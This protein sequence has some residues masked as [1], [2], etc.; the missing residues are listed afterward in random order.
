MVS[1]LCKV[2]KWE[3]KK[4]TYGQLLKD[5]RAC[6]TE[7]SKMGMLREKYNELWLF[8]LVNLGDLETIEQYKDYLQQ[9]L[10][11]YDDFLNGK[12]NYDTMY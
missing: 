2:V 11:A 7:S 3:C 5:L 12:I 1:G 6:K 4:F 8:V 10:K 9:C